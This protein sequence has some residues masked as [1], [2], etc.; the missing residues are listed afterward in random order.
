MPALQKNVPCFE[1]LQDKYRERGLIIAGITKV[2]ASQ[3][4]AT[5]EKYV[6]EENFNYLM[7]I[8]DETF[9]DLAY[10]V[11]AIPHMVLIDKKGVV[12][13]YIV[14]YHEPEVLEQE[15]LKLLEE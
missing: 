8:S 15:I 3:S 5:I 7:G 11:G 1:E 13:K 4:V 6:K 9:N 10:G 2:D 12:R 14:G